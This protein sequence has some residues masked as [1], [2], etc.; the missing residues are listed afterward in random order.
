MV[1]VWGAGSQTVSTFSLD[2]LSIL[3]RAPAKTHLIQKDYEIF[4]FKSQ[5]D[6]QSNEFSWLCSR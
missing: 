3:I 4:S 2:L 5:P 6:F 1:P